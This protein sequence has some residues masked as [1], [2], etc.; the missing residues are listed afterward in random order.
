MFGPF[1]VVVV[2]LIHRLT[3]ADI[4]CTTTAYLFFFPLY[5]KQKTGLF[6]TSS[7]DI[8]MEN[9]AYEGPNAMFGRHDW[10]VDI[11]AC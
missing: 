3:Q 11:M 2:Q 5:E 8:N 10:L 7:E 9:Y 1:V 6:P 4:S